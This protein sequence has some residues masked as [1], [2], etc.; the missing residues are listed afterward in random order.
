MKPMRRDKNRLWST[1]RRY[2]PSDFGPIPDVKLERFYVRLTVDGWVAQ[3]VTIENGRRF[4]GPPHRIEDDTGRRI[5]VI[6]ALVKGL[7]TRRR[8]DKSG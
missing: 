8:K 2:V 4:L 5:F 3:L 6:A 7:T 1:G